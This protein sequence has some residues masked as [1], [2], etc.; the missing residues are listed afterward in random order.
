VSCDQAAQTWN[1]S[2]TPPAGVH[3][4]SN[5]SCAASRAAARNWSNGRPSRASSPMPIFMTGS[6]PGG[7][8][9]AAGGR[10]DWPRS[11]DP[12]PTST[13]PPAGPGRGCAWWT[14][15]TSAVARSAS[16]PTRAWTSSRP[17]CGCP[18]HPGRGGRGRARRR[19]TG[20]RARGPHPDGRRGGADRSRRIGACADRPGAA[21]RGETRCAQGAAD[22][23]FD[24]LFDFRAWRFADLAD[25]ETDR[26]IQLL[27]GRR[28][29]LTPT[30]SVACAVLMGDD[31]A[32]TIPPGIGALPGVRSRWSSIRPNRL[33]RCCS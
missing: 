29:F 21:Q 8:S 14:T 23:D 1:E 31:E 6:M 13:V 32:I 18:R 17:T 33:A 9:A 2:G 24:W 11:S 10:R 28:I 7:V 3:T 15:R 12:G 26:L 5:P 16:W 27:L 22:P 25:A 20:G 30:L 4:L 19:P